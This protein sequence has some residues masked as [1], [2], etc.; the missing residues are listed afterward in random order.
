MWHVKPAKLRKALSGWPGVVEDL[1]WG[2]D[3][4]WSVGGKMFCVLG[5]EGSGGPSFKVPDE[6]FLAMTDRPGIVPAPYM[7]R[8]RWV[9]LEALDT[10]PDD[11]LI[12]AIRTSYALVKARLPKNLQR[13]LGAR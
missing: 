3:H 2:C 13:E 9:K 8:A 4:V 1:K 11:E 7:A 6:A 10:L 12:E 5:E